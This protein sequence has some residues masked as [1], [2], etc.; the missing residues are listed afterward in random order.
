MKKCPYCAEEIQDEAIICRY[1]ERDLSIPPSKPHIPSG[2]PPAPQAQKKS[3]DKKLTL[4]LLLLFGV[5]GV[6]GL[7]C[8][9]ALYPNLGL[10][11]TRPTSTSRLK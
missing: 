11:S 4:I 10:S 9:I 3:T 6:I 2:Q 1:C 5:F 8:L 7:C